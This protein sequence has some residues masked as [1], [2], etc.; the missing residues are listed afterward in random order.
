MSTIPSITIHNL[1]VHEL[2][3][4]RHEKS[5]VRIR[6]SV[7]DV[8]TPNVQTLAQRIHDSFHSRE[9][10]ALYG[11]FSN[12][13]RE[14]EFPGK[15]NE[16]LTNNNFLELTKI[17]MKELKTESDKELLSTGGYIV[18]IDYSTTSDKYVALTMIKPTDVIQIDEEL[19]PQILEAL[20]LKKL[21]QAIRINQNSYSESIK[22]DNEITE[23]SNEDQV[24]QKNYLS[25]LAARNK[26]EPSLYFVK[27]AGCEE[28]MGSGKSTS[29]VY[30]AVK[31]IFEATPVLTEHKKLADHELTNFFIGKKNQQVRLVDVV[32]VLKTKFGALLEEDKIDSFFDAMLTEMNGENYKIPSLFYPSD[33]VVNRKKQVKYSADG[34]TLSVEAGLISKT[35]SSSRFYWNKDTG[36]LEIKTDE[37]LLQ[38]LENKLI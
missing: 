28:G 34:I 35:D 14:G 17:F 3:K 13:G 15:Y 18:C 25:F 31:K 22:E 24:E 6:E 1:V 2:I 19:L 32:D 21:H 10:V 8:T 30:K 5:T 23:E 33:S 16:W 4:Q 36:K 27:A 20:D 37:K 29:A 9:Q 12:D 26:D 11:I 38:E 7:L